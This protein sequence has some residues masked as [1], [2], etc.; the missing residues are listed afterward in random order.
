MKRVI[1]FFRANGG[2]NEEC[3]AFEAHFEKIVLRSLCRHRSINLDC[4]AF[5]QIPRP[6]PCSPSIC[7]YATP[8]LCKARLLRL[9]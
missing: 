3:G 2:V 8:D 5:V 9:N 7:W 1:L 4:E 6:G